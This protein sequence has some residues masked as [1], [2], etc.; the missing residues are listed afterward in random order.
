MKCFIEIDKDTGK[1]ISP[2]VQEKG[3]CISS[4]IKEVTEEE[5]IDY[6]A[7]YNLHKKCK[8]HLVEDLPFGYYYQRRCI[9]CG[10]DLG[11]L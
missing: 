9:I 4:D 5:Y 10:K 1:P 2:E 7:Y 11:L 3:L 6:L 8:R